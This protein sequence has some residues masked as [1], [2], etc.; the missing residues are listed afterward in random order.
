MPTM[1]ALMGTARYINYTKT[2]HSLEP[3]S[4][5]PSPMKV[6]LLV[7]VVAHAYLYLYM[8]ERC[9]V[10]MAMHMRRRPLPLIQNQV[11]ETPS[12]SNT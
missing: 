10:W 9:T 3:G 2:Q 4:L 11:Q 7:V 12:M 8:I 1:L 6:V 5:P